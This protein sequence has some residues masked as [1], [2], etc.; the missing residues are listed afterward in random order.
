M[1]DLPQ[2]RHPSVTGLLR[3]FDFGHLPEV[4]QDAS[5]PFADLA[6]LL[7]ERLPDSAELTTALRKLLE[8]KDCAV[9]AT[10]EANEAR[11]PGA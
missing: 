5:E 11:S 3:W 1:S 6:A 8:A 7:V 10:I 9:R 2:G 4:L